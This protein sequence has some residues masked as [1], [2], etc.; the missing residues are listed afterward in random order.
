MYKEEVATLLGVSVRAIERY[1]QDG[2]L[3]AS[4]EM[5]AKGGRK[6]FYDPEEVQK[7]KAAMETTKIIEPSKVRHPDMGIGD[8]I[9]EQQSQAL[10]VRSDRFL[11]KF[12][13]LASDVTKLVSK[14][15]VG[16]G[17]KLTL[18]LVEASQLAGLSKGYLKKAIDGGELKAAKRGKG[19]N[20]KRT[21]LEEW[22][23][24][25]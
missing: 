7:L 12:D 5:R 3:T 11:D 17:E 16:I 15:N 23:K 8:M 14:Q 25:L 2:K 10:I 6:A 20:I 13:Q 24:G 22:V 4:Y 21:D 19:W 9:S 1:T 18:S